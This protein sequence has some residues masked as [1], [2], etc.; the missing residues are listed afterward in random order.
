LVGG[1]SLGDGPVEIADARLSRKPLSEDPQ[2]GAQGPRWSLLG[3]GGGQFFF[4]AAARNGLFPPAALAGVEAAVRD[5]LGHQLVWGLDL[6][7]GGGAANLELPG[8]SP[9]PERFIELTGG[10]SLWRD[11]ELTDRL[12]LSLGAR[13]AFLYLARTFQNHPELPGQSFFTLT[14]GVQT[15][16]SWRFSERWSAVARGRVNYLFYN[17]DGARNLGF[18]ELALG[19]DYALGL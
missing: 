1:V 15:A 5:D 11:F 17:V 13:V 14:P 8:V 2:K 12:T 7:V 18:A 3:S 19:V 6:A 10:A 16:L 9:I 4:D